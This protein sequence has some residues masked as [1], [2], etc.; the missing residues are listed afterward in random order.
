MFIIDLQDR[1]SQAFRNMRIRFFLF[2][3][4][5]YQDRP[6]FIAIVII[7]FSPG[8]V[9]ANIDLVFNSTEA[10]PSVQD[11]EKPIKDAKDNGSAPFTIQSFT[12]SVKEDNDDD[13]LET[14]EIALIV[15]V[16]VILL[17]LVL[18][19]VL[20]CNVSL[21]TFIYMKSKKRY[22]VLSNNIFVRKHQC[23]FPTKPTQETL[24]GNN[25]CFP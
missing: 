4:P 12:V 25:I 23:M 5:L 13:G 16:I 14:W 24:L 22:C 11:I 15:S 21:F 3:T 20:V 1:G 2:L 17:I 9:I 6:G 10:S 7:S 18:I 19:S 8:S